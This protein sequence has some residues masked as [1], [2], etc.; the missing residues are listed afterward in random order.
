MKNLIYLLVFTLSCTSSSI[1]D[2]SKESLPSTET[3]RLV[4]R[5]PTINYESQGN[6]IAKYS[7]DQEVNTSI[8]MDA[9]LT[10]HLKKIPDLIETNNI[11]YLKQLEDVSHIKHLYIVLSMKNVNRSHELALL[12]KFKQLETLILTTVEVIPPEIFNLPKLK[13]LHLLYVQPLIEIPESIRNLKQLEDLS[14]VN[15]DKIKK[16]PDGIYELKNLKTFRLIGFG[17]IGSISSKIQNLNKLESITLRYN[18]LKIPLSIGNMKN[19]KSLVIDNNSIPN[20]LYDTIYQLQN[21]NTLGIRIDNRENYDGI[22]KLQNLKTLNIRSNYLSK[23]IGQLKKLKSLF[24]YGRFVDEYPKELCNLEYLRGLSV[25][26]ENDTI[27]PEF[28][29]SFDQLEYLA[30]LY[31]EKLKNL[32]LL[33]FGLNNLPDSIPYNLRHLNGIMMKL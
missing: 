33:R 20:E 30:L 4:K 24:L 31:S 21:L 12:S 22:S 14:I 13:T 9:F 17:D 18:N 19:I 25:G 32:K 16:L 2:T 11:D 27:A 7:F 23:E 15:P 29:S 28:I 26:I 5:L 3:K 8:M 10:E 6:V 1:P